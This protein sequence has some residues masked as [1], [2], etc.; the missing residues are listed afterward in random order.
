MSKKDKDKDKAPE[1]PIDFQ[2]ES[3]MLNYTIEL[4][5]KDILSLDNT[6]EVKTETLRKKQ[7]K[8]DTLKKAN[9]LKMMKEGELEELKMNHIA[10]N[11]A[12]DQLKKEMEHL[13]ATQEEEKQKAIAELK[14]TVTLLNK[15]IADN[16][17][18]VRRSDFYKE[19]ME[20]FHADVEARDKQ[21]EKMK[22][23]F[24]EDLEK[25]EIAHRMK[26]SQLKQKMKESIA[27]TEEKVKELNSQ[28]M[29]VSTKLILLQNHQ[30]LIQ[31]EYQSQQIDE[32]SQKIKFYQ[33]KYKE[34]Q[35][36]MEIH[37]EVELSL[38]EK[39][40]N[41]RNDY[42]TL[43]NKIGNNPLD[44][45]GVQESKIF[46]NENTKNNMGMNSLNYKNMINLE[47]KVINLE[48]RLKQKNKEY[49]M[50]KDNAEYIELRLKNY[51]E[52][53]AGLFRFFEESLQN[54]YEDEELKD[55][56]EIYLNIDSIKRGDF[57]NFTSEE[58]YSILV[59]LMKYLTPLINSNEIAVGNSAMGNVNLRFHYNN[60]NTSNSNSSSL[61]G[62]VIKRHME[63]TEFRKIINT[64]GNMKVSQN[65]AYSMSNSSDTLPRIHK[66]KFSSI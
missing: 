55:N 49:G 57:S 6:N 22:A 23:D 18:K 41:L 16:D 44:T 64:K 17:E 62:S 63:D 24:Q 39:N 5:Q 60:L 11:Q 45:D 15:K 28:N 31:L 51:E 56:Q 27:K 14:D 9:E 4:K 19:Q 7:E 33:D 59:I 34:L 36:E 2:V 46:S 25:Q 61:G 1:V 29:D 21:I 58:K 42:N 12:Y 30:L 40:K 10:L 52:K 53:Y 26:F 20:K 47:K 54:F 38:A 43:K 50:L 65:Y 66:N 37:K 13:K 48:K 32:Q 8:I 35:R 3:K